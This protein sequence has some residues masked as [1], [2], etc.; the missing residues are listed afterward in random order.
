[1]QMLV[2]DLQRQWLGEFGAI[3]MTEV[4]FA[5]LT[6]QQILSLVLT[7]LDKYPGYNL[8]SIRMPN[9]ITLVMFLFYFKPKEFLFFIAVSE[10]AIC[11]DM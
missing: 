2:G 5:F 7:L 4:M 11:F 1:M 6:G 10:L 9:I 3:P 8:R